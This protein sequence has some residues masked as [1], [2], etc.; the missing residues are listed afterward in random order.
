MPEL[1]SFLCAESQI[2]HLVSV[3]LLHKSS[4]TITNLNP[5]KWERERL[6]KRSEVQ[7][8]K[9]RRWVGGKDE[10]R[11]GFKQRC[12][13]SAIN[14]SQLGSVSLSTLKERLSLFPPLFQILSAFI[15]HLLCI[16]P[17]S[18]PETFCYDRIR[19]EEGEVGRGGRERRKQI[20]YILSLLIW[21]KPGFWLWYNC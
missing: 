17:W 4:A 10:E 11:D 8:E 7:T 16:I 15:W 12:Y 2:N 21:H 6:I 14:I 18:S 13:V 19:K 3:C 9:E 1:V 20:K 5:R